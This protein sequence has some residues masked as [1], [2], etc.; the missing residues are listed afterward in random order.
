MSRHRLFDPDEVVERHNEEFDEGIA[1]LDELLAASR[2]ALADL[3]KLV[4]A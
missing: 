3:D 4:A 2:Q 1:G